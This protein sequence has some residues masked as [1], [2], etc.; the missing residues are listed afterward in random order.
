MA[1]NETTG[2]P[3]SVTTLMLQLTPEQQKQMREFTGCEVHAMCVQKTM[4]EGAR[5][6]QSC[7]LP[8]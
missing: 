1:Y 5:S 2:V 8:W 3:H 7:V 6:I 4:V